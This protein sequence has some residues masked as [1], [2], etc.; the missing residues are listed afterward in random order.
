MSRWSP[1]L[2]LALVCARASGFP[3][4]DDIQ[5]R[6]AELQTLRDQ[7]REFEDRITDQQRTE[8]STL[9]LL[10]SYDRKGTLL[11]TLVGR[12]RKQEESLKK[13]IDG[14]RKGLLGLEEQLSFLKGHYA[15]YVVSAY[16]AGRTADMEL[17]LSS[18]S[19]NQAAVRNEYL[20]R[21]AAQ[22]R[23]DA[24]RIQTKQRQMAEGQA[25]A[26]RQLS[27]ERRLLA[28][29][30]AE[31]DRLAALTEERRGVL[32]QVRRDRR[33]LQREVERKLQ[34]ARDLENIISRL[35]EADRIRREHD[36]A[37]TT[38]GTRPPLPGASLFEGRRGRLPWPVTEG[39]VV[40][41]F[42]NQRHPTLRTVTHN[43]GID[44][45]VQPGSPVTAV[46]EG[47]VSRIW[48]LP[49]YGNLV[50]V[51]H[52]NGYRTVYTHLA[53]IQVAEGQRI[54]EGEVIGASGESVD[55]PRLHFELWKD[56][57]KQNPETWLARR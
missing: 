38:E 41:R 45:A 12:L 6:Q 26:Q 15:K 55:G 16:K 13:T 47:E 10:D 42:G 43:T 3:L 23:A 54:A 39:A 7:I 57:D 31:E 44:I 22:R 17:L 5:K 56:R 21:F 25:R 11:R 40:A 36:A 1:A 32:D 9:E 8:Q 14:T 27:E 33:L 35:V 20:K 18:A 46:A 50:I 30:G 48:W 19:L 49:S 29:K 53:D 24:G 37:A 51:H 34:A 52:G 28:E 2:L 4:Q